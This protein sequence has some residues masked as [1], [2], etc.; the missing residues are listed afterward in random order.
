MCIRSWSFRRRQKAAEPCTSA[1]APKRRQLVLTRTRSRRDGSEVF[2]PA[3]AGSPPAP[4]AVGS[5]ARTSPLA[6]AAR[7]GSAVDFELP[8]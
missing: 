7:A 3:V 6:H 4:K 1:P 5:L 2:L 8:F